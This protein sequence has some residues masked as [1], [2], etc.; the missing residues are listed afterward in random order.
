M[1]AFSHS[2][3][4]YLTSPLSFSSGHGETQRSSPVSI[5]H[6]RLPAR[7]LPSPQMIRGA[8]PRSLPSL[9]SFT[10]FPQL[11]QRNGCPT[12][13]SRVGLGALA[14]FMPKRQSGVPPLCCHGRR[15]RVQ[16]S[17]PLPS[18]PTSTGALDSLISRQRLLKTAGGRGIQN[19]VQTRQT[20]PL[21]LARRPPMIGPRGF[22]GGA[23]RA[24]WR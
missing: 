4:Q 23:Q 9:G 18:P 13:R 24:T 6:T 14:S 20:E 21:P 1:L 22:W 11:V 10:L 7:S 16:G 5:N 12:S 19:P 8:S 3:A 15:F 2:A 17:S